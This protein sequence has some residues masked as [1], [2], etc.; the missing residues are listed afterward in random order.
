MLRP[1]SG[2]KTFTLKS[3]DERFLRFRFQK[4]ITAKCRPLLALMARGKALSSSW[5]LPSDGCCVAS[6]ELPA[7]KLLDLYEGK[8]LVTPFKP[9]AVHVMARESDDR[10]KLH[11][12]LNQSVQR[13]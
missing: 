10:G 1:S 6:N 12:F 2:C 3:A 4:C 9:I 13:G 11:A 8:P 7:T 5:I